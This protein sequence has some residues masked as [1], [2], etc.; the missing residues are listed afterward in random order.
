MKLKVHDGEEECQEER[1]DD[2]EEGRRFN[3]ANATPAKI[4]VP[5]FD[6]KQN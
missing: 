3:G 1:N 5:K 2:D 4:D 6:N